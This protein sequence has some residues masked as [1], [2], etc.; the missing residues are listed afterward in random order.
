MLTTVVR[1]AA[2][3]GER[4]AR[5]VQ[6]WADNLPDAPFEGYLLTAGLALADKSEG[7]LAAEIDVPIARVRQYVEDSSDA[8]S[9]AEQ[10][11]LRRFFNRRGIYEV[12]LFSW[13]GWRGLIYAPWTLGRHD[14]ARLEDQATTARIV[15]FQRGAG[16]R[17]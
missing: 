11:A 13:F 16:R 17:L 15:D 7:F 5:G 4:T 3:L 9:P 1:K 2:D 10:R 14:A 6:G 12:R 8:L